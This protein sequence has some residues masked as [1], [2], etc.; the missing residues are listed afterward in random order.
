[1]VEEVGLGDAEL[2]VQYI[3]EFAL[4]P[5]NIS[6]AENT[7]HRCPLDID[8]RPVIRVLEGAVRIVVIK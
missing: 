1:M 3:Q 4:D 8:H 6:F 5:T 7:G 2:V